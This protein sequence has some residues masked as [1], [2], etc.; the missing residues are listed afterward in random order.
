[1]EKGVVAKQR[2]AGRRLHLSW[3]KSQSP[4]LQRRV[5]GREMGLWVSGWPKG[6]CAVHSGEITD[7]EEL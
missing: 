3:V 5:P 2:L 7:A 1:M 4:Q 6:P